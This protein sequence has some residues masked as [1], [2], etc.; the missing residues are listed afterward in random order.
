MTAERG[1]FSVGDDVVLTD[2]RRGRVVRPANPAG[3]WGIGVGKRPTLAPVSW[4]QSRDMSP[5]PP[6]EMENK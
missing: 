1:G 5:T 3:F 4:V 2:G 6:K